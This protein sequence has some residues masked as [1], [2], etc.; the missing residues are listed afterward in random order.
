[1][2]AFS[3]ALLGFVRPAGGGR[4]SRKGVRDVALGGKFQFESGGDKR[5]FIERNREHFSA[6]ELSGFGIRS[7]KNGRG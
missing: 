7:P 2:A 5:K 3:S 4:A 6:S 1:M